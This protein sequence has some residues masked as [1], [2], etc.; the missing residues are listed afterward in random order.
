MNLAD[1]HINWQ[2][3]SAEQAVVSWESVLSAES[4]RLASRKIA[5]YNEIF[6]LQK[7]SVKTL[8]G[9]RFFLQSKQNVL[10][11][12]KKSSGKSSLCKYLIFNALPEN[13]LASSY[14]LSY[15]TGTTD[16]QDFIEANVDKR[17]KKVS[18]P[19]RSA[20][21]LHLRPLAC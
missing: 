6:V 21:R 7:S 5:S 11:G 18:A 13:F 8:Y 4:E 16:I 2:G 1:A 20:R 15:V 10:C 19:P 12:G 14:Q 9:L 3:K 17:R